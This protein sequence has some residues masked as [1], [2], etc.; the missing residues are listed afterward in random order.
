MSASRA[1]RVIALVVVLAAVGLGGFFALEWREVAGR[2]WLAQARRAPGA[3]VDAPLR[4]AVRLLGVKDE[5]IRE[6]LRVEAQDLRVTF[7]PSGPTATGAPRPGTPV[8]SAVVE[9]VSGRRLVLFLKHNV[10]REIVPEDAF[11][12]ESDEAA[13]GEAWALEELPEA[14]ALDPGE[15]HTIDDPAP[16]SLRAS[17]YGETPPKSR[18][19]PHSLGVTVFNPCLLGVK[20]RRAGGGFE[21]PVALEIVGPTVHFVAL[22]P[23]PP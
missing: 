1:T 9:N 11:A 15:R 16:G 13:E 2:F 23:R 19:E 7:R 21:V 8:A 5:R 12:I 10:F 6:L 17:W 20:P 22:D 14:L 3:A 18:E 4:R